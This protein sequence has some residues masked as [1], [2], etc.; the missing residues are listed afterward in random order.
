MIV[1]ATV[2]VA[3][4]AAALERHEA[5]QGRSRGISFPGAKH[6]S[7][8]WSSHERTRGVTGTYALVNLEAAAIF[9]ICS[10]GSSISDNLL[11]SSLEIWRVRGA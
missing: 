4:A 9:V 11:Q 1:T 7:L 8:L 6:V 2:V 10:L 3:A 5:L